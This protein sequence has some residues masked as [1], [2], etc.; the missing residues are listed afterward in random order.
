[1]RHYESPY[2]GLPASEPYRG[3]SNDGE[4]LELMRRC[5]A[6]CLV[7]DECAAVAMTAHRLEGIFGGMGAGARRTSRNA[8]A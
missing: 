7:R 3:W 6:R 2:R 4:G 8:A 5:C 1:M